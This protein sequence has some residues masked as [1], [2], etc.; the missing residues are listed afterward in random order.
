MREFALDGVTCG[1][2]DTTILSDVSFSIGAGE[3]LCLRGPNGVGK[4]TL[5]RSMLGFL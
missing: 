4:T 5:F 2:K 3:A 1:Y